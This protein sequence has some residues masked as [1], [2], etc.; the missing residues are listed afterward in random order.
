MKPEPSNL[1]ANP[2]PPTP[3]ALASVS[4]YAVGDKVT[5][6]RNIWSAANE[7]SPMYLCAYRGDILEIRRLGSCGWACYVAHPEKESGPMFGVEA[8]EI[9]PHN[10]KSQKGK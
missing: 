1:A 8:G 5:A 4:G 3:P 10:A 9:K 2:V 6:T 7:D